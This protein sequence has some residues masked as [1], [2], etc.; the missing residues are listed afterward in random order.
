MSVIS[1]HS[2][3]IYEDM[4]I[5]FK[6]LITHVIPEILFNPEYGM[7]DCKVTERYATLCYVSL[8]VFTYEIRFKT[9]S[10]LLFETEM[11]C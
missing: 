5:K 8:C 3:Q 6:R 4:L 11:L 10:V 2:Q 7:T 9:S 1:H